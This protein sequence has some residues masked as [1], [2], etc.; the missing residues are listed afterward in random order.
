MNRHKRPRE[1]FLL[2]RVLMAVSSLS[3]LFFLIAIKG[4]ALLSDS[5]LASICAAVI[6][7]STS[8]LALRVK[9]SLRNDDTA[10]LKIVDVEDSRDHLLVYLFAVLV[11]LFQAD[12]DTPRNALL[13]CSVLALVLFLL[14]HLRLYYANVLFAVFH[15]KIFTLTTEEGRRIALISKKEKVIP[16]EMT[17]HRVSNFLY[18][19]A[20]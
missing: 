3:P 19:D 9:A 13:F 18:I 7:I 1:P 11:P 17:L 5:L 8:M 4:S 2:L 16:S 14:V 10:T 15:F 20:G 6:I 12:L